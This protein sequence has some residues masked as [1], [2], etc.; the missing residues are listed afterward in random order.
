MVNAP[1]PA[2]LGALLSRGPWRWLRRRGVRPVRRWR[3]V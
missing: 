2:F 3:G 1:C